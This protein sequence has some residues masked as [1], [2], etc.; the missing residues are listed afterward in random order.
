MTHRG[1]HSWPPHWVWT[2]GTEKSEPQGE[3]GI[4]RKVIPS[5]IPPAKKCFLY[6][7]YD[8]ATYIACLFIDNSAFCAQI[9]SLLQDHCN[10]PIAEIGSIDIPLLLRQGSSKMELG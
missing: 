6:I 2:G 4:L 8:G 10:C 1:A 9:V 7:E 3:V 5:N